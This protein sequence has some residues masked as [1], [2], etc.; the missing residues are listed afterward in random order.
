MEKLKRVVWEDRSGLTKWNPLAVHYG[1]LEQID[2]NGVSVREVPARLSSPLLEPWGQIPVWLSVFMIHEFNPSVSSFSSHIPTPRKQSTVKPNS[3]LQIG[4]ILGHTY[5][6]IWC[7]LTVLSFFKIK[8]CECKHKRNV[9]M[10]SISQIIFTFFHILL[11]WNCT[12]F[13]VK[14]NLLHILFC[15]NLWQLFNLY[16]GILLLTYIHPFDLQY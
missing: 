3:Y 15:D 11:P 12:I 1:R 5:F 8:V 10:H 14:S 4:H 7:F 6:K 13:F 2:Q 9:Q 16:L